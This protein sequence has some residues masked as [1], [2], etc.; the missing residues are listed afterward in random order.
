MGISF[1]VYSEDSADGQDR[2][3]PLDFIPRLIRKSE[4][5]QVEKGLKQRV[6]AL[7]M[8]IED[9]YNKQDFLNES[10]MDKSLV[11]DSPAYKKYCVDVKLKHNTWSHICGSDLIKAHDGKFYVLED[12]LRVPSGV[13]YMLENRMIM[14]RVFPDLFSHY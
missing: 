10:D 3:W 11:L 8:F 12:N 6:K 4:W 9:C 2:M 5:L 1:R 7:N 14:K 13:S